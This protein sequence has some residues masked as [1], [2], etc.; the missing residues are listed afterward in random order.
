MSAF[1]IFAGFLGIILGVGLM[2]GY[3][4]K[5]LK[6][7]IAIA[8]KS[9]ET[10]PQSHNGLRFDP[11]P[12][13]NHTL[14]SEGVDLPEKEGERANTVSDITESHDSTLSA[15]SSNVIEEKEKVTPDET[16]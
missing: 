11:K 8:I 2:Y 3:Y 9:F 12:K 14:K 15:P 6:K 16:H 5:K 10:M 1:T 4:K 7:Q 13:P